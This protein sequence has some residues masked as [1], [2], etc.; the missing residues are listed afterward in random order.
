MNRIIRSIAAVLAICV[1]LAVLPISAL[2]SDTELAPTGKEYFGTV[3]FSLGFNLPVSTGDILLMGSEIKASDLT[4]VTVTIGESVFTVTSDTPYTLPQDCLIENIRSS[5]FKNSITLSP[6]GESHSFGEPTWSFVYEN[7]KYR[8][9]ATFVCADCGDS[10]TISDRSPIVDVIKEPCGFEGGEFSCVG[11]VTSPDGS[12]YTGSGTGSLAAP[13]TI[14]YSIFSDGNYTISGSGPIPDGSI[15]PY[16]PDG[17]DKS[18]VKRVFLG[19]SSSITSIGAENF[20]GFSSL[21]VFEFN[22]NPVVSIGD[23]AFCDC[24]LQYLNIPGTVRT[25]GN[26]AYDNCSLKSGIDNCSEVLESIGDGAFRG[27]FASSIYLPGSVNYIGKSPFTSISVMF[28]SCYHGSYAMEYAMANRYHIEAL[29]AHTYG[30]PRFT[31]SNDHS[32]CRMFLDCEGCDYTRQYITYDITGIAYPETDTEYAKEVYTATFNTE[33][34]TYTAVDVVGGGKKYCTFTI[35]LGELG[36]DIVFEVKRDTNFFDAIDDATWDTLY[37]LSDED[38]LFRDL[39]SKPLSAFSNADE[40][41][42][43]AEALL[44]SVVTD[45]MT[46]YA[47]YFKRIRS[48]GITLARPVVGSPITIDGNG[49]QS[50]RPLVTLCDSAHCSVDRDYSEW[51]TDDGQGLTMLNGRFR[52]GKPY[53]ASMILASDFGYWLDEDTVVAVDGGEVAELSGAFALYV[54]LRTTAVPIMGDTDSNGIVTILDAT[55]IQRKLAGYE[56][57]DFNPAAL[58]EGPNILSILDAMRIQRWLA[59]YNV[60]ANIGRPIMW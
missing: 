57:E 9:D 47:C 35:D 44:D 48:V 26:Y 4:A 33:D 8:A 51:L 41:N 40:F 20:R 38:H 43:D 31:W 13:L 15:E 36:E 11:T 52:P 42:K 19:S 12:I 45:D 3:T 16:L 18:M 58:S 55:A 34:S 24:D 10:V 1:L 2:A 54:S 6:I 5:G 17:H 7:K 49:V 25:I 30:E 14:S 53:Y 50:V 59:G 37:A 23:Y 27:S 39:A 29:D 21:Q 56:V 22:D 60:S 46:V 28:I 32:A